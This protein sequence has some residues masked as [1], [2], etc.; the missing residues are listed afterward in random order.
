MKSTNTS[1][2]PN[3]THLDATLSLVTTL[4]QALAHGLSR[5]APTERDGLQSLTRAF[6]NTP[7][8]PSLQTSVAAILDGELLG[9]HLALLAAAR[10]SLLGAAHDALQSAAATHLGYTIADEAPA[11]PPLSPAPLTRT[12]MDSAQQWLVELALSG[13]AALDRQ[14]IHPMLSALRPLQEHPPLIRLASLLTGFS[15]ELLDAIPTT[16]DTIPLGRWCDLWMTAMLQTVALPSPSPTTPC[17]GIL[18][19]LGLDLRHH[20]HL[21]S[22]IVHATLETANTTRLVKLHFSAWKVDAIAGLEALTLLTPLA[23]KLFSTFETATS[24]AVIDL[25]LSQAGDLTWNEDAA[26][27]SALSPISLTGA[28]ISRPE[29]RDRHPLQLALPFLTKSAPELP[30]AGASPWLELDELYQTRGATGFTSLLR[31]DADWFSQPLAADTKKGPKGLAD[32]F[33]KI[34]KIKE[35]ALPILQE[36]A[37]RL[38]RKS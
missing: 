36:R 21:V 27:P 11:T 30:I 23:P 1:T 13:F 32:G 20:D 8:G 37:S 26:H 29:P 28:I 31:W 19:V 35:F 33:A 12:L 15:H 25:P 6:S 18:T 9:H 10:A 4:D 22:A 14:T 34:S 7:L 16:S 17:S 2:P 24:F 38:L 5:I 3:P